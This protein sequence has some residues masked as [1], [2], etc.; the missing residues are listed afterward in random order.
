MITIYEQLYQCWYRERIKLGE[1]SSELE[2]R[3]HINSL[4]NIELLE[5]ISDANAEIL[6]K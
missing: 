1:S 6:Q 4:S 2:F 5:E 3:K